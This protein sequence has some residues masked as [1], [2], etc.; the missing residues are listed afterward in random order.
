MIKERYTIIKKE[1]SV[2]IVN[3]EINSIRKKNIKKTGLRAYSNNLIGIAGFLGEEGEKEA[4]K[5]AV[6]NLKNMV[7]YLPAPCAE[8][9]EERKVGRLLFAEDEFIKETEEILKCLRS[10][11]PEFIFSH[12]LNLCQD[13]VMLSND[14]GTDLKFQSD[15]MNAGIVY[16]MKDSTNIFDGF[17]EVTGDRYERKAFI[18]Y[19]SS[20]LAAHLNKTSLPAGSDKLP[21]IFTSPVILKKFIDDLHGDTYGSGASLFSGKAGEKLFDSRFSLVNSK[22]S[23]ITLSPFFD[24]EGTTLEDDT[25]YFIKDGVF[26]S[27]YSDKKTAMKFDQSITGNASAEYDRVPVS[28]YEGMMIVPCRDDLKTLLDGQHG[29]LVVMASGGDFTADG[30]FGTPVQLSFLTDG[31]R[32]LGRLPDIQVDSTV[33]DMFGKD[34]RG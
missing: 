14:L 3:S 1:L 32:L 5:R 17:I 20:I 4:E 23:D 29:I 19:S 21:V 10:D 28:S 24:S 12:K 30:S 7:E 27:P 9:T 31:E 11:F 6:R 8:K 26:I 22:R 2:N 34:F 33:Y 18:D 15:Y 16:K 13:K 25:Y